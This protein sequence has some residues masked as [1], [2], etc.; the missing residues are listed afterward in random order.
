MDASRR[1]WRSRGMEPAEGLLGCVGESS[2]G[3]FLIA[4]LDKRSRGKVCLE[5]QAG[6]KLSREW[7]RPEPGLSPNGS[8]R[9]ATG[10]NASQR[11]AT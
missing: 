2:V 7:S 8:Q 9:D 4:M 6:P 11:D 5:R 1:F 10:R 3:G